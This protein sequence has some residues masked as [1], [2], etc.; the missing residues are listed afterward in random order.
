MASFPPL[1]YNFCFINHFFPDISTTF[2]SH[3]QNFSFLKSSFGLVPYA[4]PTGIEGFDN[5]L[6]GK[7][8]PPRRKPSP[9]FP[10]ANC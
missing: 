7:K 8:V 5:K 4:F 10:G 3:L 2:Q 6:V 1:Y 9:P